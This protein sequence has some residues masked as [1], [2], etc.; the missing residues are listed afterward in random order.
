MDTITSLIL[1]MLTMLL[2][3]RLISSKECTPINAFAAPL[4]HGAIQ[5]S[6]GFMGVQLTLHTWTAFSDYTGPDFL[7]STVFHFQLF[8]YFFFIL[9]RA[10]D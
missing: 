7:C 2:S 1:L 10:V 8:F 4:G 9:G 5:N 3:L 6:L